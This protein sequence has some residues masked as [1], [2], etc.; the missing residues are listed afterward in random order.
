M[1]DENFKILAGLDVWIVDCLSMKNIRPTHPHLETVLEW[2]RI[3]NPK[4]A[5]LTHMDASM[6]YDTLTRILPK[7]VRPAYDQMVI[8]IL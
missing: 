3:V 8:E 5:Y 4:M 1:T 6:D 2:I 7:N